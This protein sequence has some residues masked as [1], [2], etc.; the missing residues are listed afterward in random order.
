MVNELEL[1]KIIPLTLEG[2]PVLCIAG[3]AVKI[4]RPCC[5]IFNYEDIFDVVLFTVQI[6]SLCVVI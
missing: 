2:Q 5:Y 3:K 4:C 1:L 6:L